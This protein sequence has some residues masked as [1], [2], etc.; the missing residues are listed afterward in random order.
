M[1]QETPPRWDLE[2]IYPGLDAEAFRRDLQRVREGLDALDAYLDAEGI[3]RD[4]PVPAEDAALAE[5]VG[6]VIARTNALLTLHGTLRAYVHGIVTT[7]SYN[8]AARRMQSELEALEVRLERRVA[9][10]AHVDHVDGDVL[11]AGHA[12]GGDEQSAACVRR[13]VGPARWVRSAHPNH[14]AL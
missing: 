5:R 11:V 3:G 8:T 2:S 13:P 14:H 1:S 9:R 6:E 10:A 7:D 4:G 12:G